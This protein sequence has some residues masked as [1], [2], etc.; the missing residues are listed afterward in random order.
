MRNDPDNSIPSVLCKTTPEKKFEDLVLKEPTLQTCKDLIREQFE[1]NKLR[2]YGIEPRHSLLLTGPAGNGKTSLAEAVAAHLMY[3][4]CTVCYE[5][6]N[7]QDLADVFKYMKARN[8]RRCVLFFDGNDAGGIINSLPMYIDRL[9]SRTVVIAVNSCPEMPDV[10]VL[11]SFQ[12]KL[13]MEKPWQPE[14]EQFVEMFV[15]RSGTSFCKGESKL[16]NTLVKEAIGR[17][18]YGCSFSE[19][20]EFCLDILRQATLEDK[21]SSMGEF[22]R[23]NLERRKLLLTGS[24]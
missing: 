13:H 16:Y 20:E 15:K 11:H 22:V 10:A 24:V 23:E 14:I 7:E 9:S 5:N 4:L 1:A 6:T 21:R 3:P 2:S 17:E 18:L 19:I 8:G 12:I